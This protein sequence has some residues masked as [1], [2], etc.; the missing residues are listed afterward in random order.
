M[1][2]RKLA[3]AEW[4]AYFDRTSTAIEGKRAEIEVASFAL[5]DQVEAGWIPI[6]GIV[7]DPKSDIV[8]IASEELDHMIHKRR[9]IAVEDGP[10]GL[11][12]IEV[13][14]DEGTAQGGQA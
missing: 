7:Y 8:E 10:G 3:K 11:E 14:D 5:G 2:A 9:E 13:V 6:F 12:S 4:Q 1:T